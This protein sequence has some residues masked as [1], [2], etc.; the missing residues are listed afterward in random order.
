MLT[1]IYGF[2]AFQNL[3]V[4]L[5]G[6]INNPQNHYIY[7]DDNG[8]FNPIPWDLNESFG[9]F[10]MLQ[11]SGQLSITQ[12]QQLSPFVNLNE[13]D[14]PII[15]K[16]LSDATYRKIYVAHM[17]TMLEE[18]FANEWYETRALEI[19]DIIASDVSADNN[20]F[21]TYSD[22]LNNINSSVGG[23]PPPNNSVIGITQLMDARVTYINAL[24][25]FQYIAPEI[26]NV[27]STPEEVTPNTLVWFSAEVVDANDVFLAYRTNQYDV[28][29]K[30]EMFDDGNHEDGAANDDV[31]GIDLTAG[32]ADIQYYIYA[33]NNNAVS[34]LPARAE[35][36]FLN[37]DITFETGDVV[38][39]EFMADNESIVTDQDGEY[40]DWIEF[41]NKGDEDINLA[42][43]Y[44]TDDED[45]L[46]QWAF[47]D[48]TI[49][50][51]DY[52]IVWADNDTDQD[53]LH[54]NF[55]LS[56]S[57][58]TIIFSADDLSPLDVIEFSQQEPDISFGRYPNGTGDFMFMVPTFSAENTNQAIGTEENIVSEN[59]FILKQNR[60]NPANDLTSID[61]ILFEGD[62]V[63]LN[64]QNAYGSIIRNIHSGYLSSGE[65]SYALKVSDLSKGLY[66][67]SLEA[68]GVVQYMKMMVQ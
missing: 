55:K 34:F 24:T 9:V 30:I 37:I 12:L 42:G 61:F 54:A 10:T 68:G 6:P 64:V 35:Y 3:L 27:L 59:G 40:D 20:K 58:E 7:K 17:K 36:E 48:I 2:L 66:I 38:I 57:G 21:Y 50:A 62:F 25:D 67:Y 22:F 26:S 15:N 53:G 65:Y 4:N 32:Y 56:A 31:Y 23:G 14:Y 46:D 60:P 41:F 18:N 51:G 45:E 16:I 47:P 63:T 29:T 5:D 28:F 49:P 39:N 11:S 13:S 44:L 33:E 8:Q 43:C 19:Q 52:L 1:V